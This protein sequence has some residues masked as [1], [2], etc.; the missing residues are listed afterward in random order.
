MVLAGAAGTGKSRAVLERVH[1]R[2][3]LTPNCKGLIVRQVARSLA[4][5]AL[6]TWERD[7]VPHALR[8]G[9]VSYYGGSQREPAQYRYSNGSSVALGGLDDPLKV[10]STE[11]DWI[12]VQEAAETTE[13]SWE[14]LSTR[15]RNGA[16]RYQQLFG[17]CNP[18]EP[19][20]W[21]LERAARGA[22]VMLES[23]HEDNPRYF[24]PDGSMTAEGVSYIARL[25]ALTGVR[26]LRLRK[27]IWAAAEGVIYEDFDTALHVIDSFPVPDSWERIW[28]IDFGYTNPFVWQEWALDEDKRAYLVREIYMSG[29]LVEDHARQ[30]MALTANSPRPSAIVCDH[31]A[32]DRA[33]FERHTG[34]G[35][36]PAHKAVT[37]GIEAVAGRFRLA[38]DGR[39]RIFFFKDALVEKDESLVDKKVPFQTTGELSGYVWAPE[40][41]SADRKQRQPVKR[42]DHGADTTRYLVCEVD[43]HGPTTVRWG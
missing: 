20:H 21:L 32:E 15:L 24:N 28:A 11:Y 10:M 8:D 33:T 19:T 25:D 30:I 16:H 17:D 7:V 40:P 31:D 22:L 18:A 34:M 38:G 3:L 1:M 39:P 14:L 9:S 26:Y 43:L 29:R 5:S 42:N 41:P 35:T 12:Y 37:E 6:K 27:G 4:T 13:L 2:N 23:K 36:V